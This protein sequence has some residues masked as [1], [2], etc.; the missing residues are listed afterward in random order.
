MLAALARREA[1]ALGHNDF[2]FI[3]EGEL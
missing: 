2:T 1:F 3:I